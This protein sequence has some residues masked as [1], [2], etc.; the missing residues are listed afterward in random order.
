MPKAK[1]EVENDVDVDSCTSEG[2]SDSDSPD[3]QPEDAIELASALL[4]HAP[5][6]GFVQYDASEMNLWAASYKSP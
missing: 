6:T 5:T 2:S 3:V 1:L 4:P